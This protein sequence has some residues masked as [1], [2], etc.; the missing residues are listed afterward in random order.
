MERQDSEFYSFKDIYHFSIE[1]QF[2][3]KE[4]NKKDMS[5]DELIYSSINLILIN[6]D[7]KE[8]SRILGQKAFDDYLKLN[9]LPRHEDIESNL[10]V[11]DEVMYSH[12]DATETERFNFLERLVGRSEKFAITPFIAA[13][14]RRKYFSGKVAEEKMSFYRNKV[15][16]FN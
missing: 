6:V 11:F 9:R 12:K 15:Y 8:V 5:D 7:K 1:N 2:K 3:I 4:F 10:E 14:L 13:K 16:N